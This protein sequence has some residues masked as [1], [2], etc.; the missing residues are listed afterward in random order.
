VCWHPAGPRGTYR[1]PRRSQKRHP[2]RPPKCRCRKVLAVAT[3]PGL[4]PGTREP[5]SL[6]L[7]ITPPGSGGPAPNQGHEAPRRAFWPLNGSVTLVGSGEFGKRIRRRSASLGRVD[8]EW[9]T[10]KRSCPVAWT[11]TRRMGVALGDIAWSAAERRTCNA[12]IHKCPGAILACS[13]RWDRSL[14]SV[15]APAGT[16]RGTLDGRFAQASSG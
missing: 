9:L 1:R 10:P 11:G 14:M 5:K 3:R 16:V 13:P 15:T 2:R 8:R 12:W 4:E 6:V 7:P